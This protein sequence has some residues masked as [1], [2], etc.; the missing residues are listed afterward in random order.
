M[1]N[2]RVLTIIALAALTPVLQAFDVTSSTMKVTLDERGSVSR[3]V[4]AKGAE[5]GCFAGSTPLF[6]LNLAKTADFGSSVSVDASAAKSVRFDPCEGGYRIVYE[7]FEDKV[8]KVV[9]RVRDGGDGKIRWRIAVVT[10]PGWSLEKTLF[11]RVMTS[12]SLGSSSRDDA[13]L[14]GVAKGGVYR[15]PLHRPG[16]YIHGKMPGS[17]VCQFAA[18][19]DER[20][21]FYYAAEDGKG[22]SKELDVKKASDGLLFQF[23]RLGFAEGKVVLDYEYVTAAI[24]GTTDNS[25]AWQDAADLYRNWAEQQQWCRVKYQNRAD[26]PAWMKDAPIFVRFYRDMIGNPDSIR[27]WMKDYWKKYYP[28]APLIMAYWGW[29][30]HG[31]WVS[32]YFPVYPSNEEFAALVKDCKAMGGHAFPWPSGYYWVLDYDKDAKTGKFAFDDHA[33]YEARHGDDYACMNR[34]GKPFRREPRWLRGGSST[35]LCGG[36]QF[37]Q[38]WWNKEVCLPLAK[39][40]C[41]LIQAD[42]TVGGAFPPCWNPKHGH[43]LGDGIWKK[44]CFYRQMVTMRETMRTCEPDSV[45]CFEEPCEIYNDVIGIQDYRTCESQADEWASVFNY[46]YHEYLPCFQSNPRRYDRV[47]QSHA[48]A[49]GQM[50]FLTPSRSDANGPHPAI[51]N[52]DFERTQEKDAGFKGWD[53]LSGYNGVSWNGRAFVDREVKHDGA[54]SMRLECEKGENFV[55]VSQN[56]LVDGSALVVG[57]KYRLSAW[58]KAASGKNANVGCCFMNGAKSIG[59]GGQVQ[60]PADNAE[61]KLVS[62][63]F[64]VPA[65]AASFRIMNN[66]GIGSKVWVDSMKIEEI[67]P[68]GP[69]EVICSGLGDYDDFM[70]RWIKLYHGP[71]RKWLAYGRQIRPPAIEAG[72]QKFSMMLYGAKTPYTGF[73]PCVFNSAWQA[74]DGSK[75]LVFV[76][77]TKERQPVGYRWNGQSAKLVL[78]PDEIKLVEVK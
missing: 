72:E 56:V 46:I 76:N 44:E 64:T 2:P 71:A 24:D 41:E 23:T 27:A 7:G 59:G 61:W 38:D 77:A 25:C 42:Q 8:E 21:L 62:R 39:L 73:R 45:V 78:D 43:E 1:K 36:T 12:M 55:Q 75:A 33:A 69:R 51:F 29:E 15:D 22:Y 52:G 9:C 3:I 58:L 14:A 18:F 60:F 57:H 30:R 70:R 65:G 54:S 53:K 35:C 17:L 68:D 40:G 37:C 66:A 10:K 20:S 28:E 34:N 19:W 50:P 48:C 4:S 32:D 63:E 26:I 16:V 5:F 74:T 31:C 47:W 49:D 13:V 67:T 6:A 11:P